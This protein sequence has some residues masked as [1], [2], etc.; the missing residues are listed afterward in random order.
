[1]GDLL[2]RTAE[3]EVT[4]GEAFVPASL[5]QPGQLAYWLELRSVAA[6]QTRS[7][8]RR[9]LLLQLTYQLFYVPIDSRKVKIPAINIELSGPGG[10]RLASIPA[11]NVLMSPIREIY[12]EKSGETAETF[13][14]DDAMPERQSTAPARTGA[15]VS[16]LAALLALVLLARHHAWW[17]FYRRRGRPFTEADRMVRNHRVPYGAALIALHRA[18]DRAQGHLLLADGVDTYVTSR[19]APADVHAEIRGFFAASQ[20]Y[21]FGAD[22]TSA[23]AAFPRSALERLSEA[24]AAN[25]RATR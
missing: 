10:K 2:Q 23:E 13:L 24:L 7:G 16:A 25:E 17:P 6:S 15:L 4:D 14:K 22:T 8:G 11:F 20:Q 12:P 19:A 18:F 5:P 9:T 1:V 3:I 21:F